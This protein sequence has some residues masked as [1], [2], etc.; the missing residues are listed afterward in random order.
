MIFPI[1]VIV[2]TILLV[3]Q[4]KILG[5]TLHSFLP[6][7]PYISAIT[8]AH[9]LYQQNTSLTCSL[10]LISSP[11]RNLRPNLFW[12][13]TRIFADVLAFILLLLLSNPFFYSVRKF[14]SID[15][16]ASVSRSWEHFKDLTQCLRLNKNNHWLIS[17]TTQNKKINNNNSYLF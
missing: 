14:Y 8:K 9:K 2:F 11:H 5:V 4:A 12:H 15:A 17:F 3:T 1:S 6:L 16:T 13:G 7:C 10:L